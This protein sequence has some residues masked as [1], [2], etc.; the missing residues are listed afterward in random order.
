MFTCLSSGRPRV[1]PPVLRHGCRGDPRSPWCA[2]RTL[3]VPQLPCRERLARS[4]PYSGPHEAF[5][6]LSRLPARPSGPHPRP[7][8]SGDRGAGRLGRPVRLRSRADDLSLADLPQ[9]PPKPLRAAVAALR[10]RPGARS[11]RAVLGRRDGGRARG[12]RISRGK[13]GRKRGGGGRRAARRGLSPG[14]RPRGRSSAQVSHPG[15]RGGGRTA[16]GRSPRR[17][18]GD[19]P[20]GRQ[21][22]EERR[23]RAAAPRL[24]LRQSGGGAPSR[25]PG[26]AAGAGGEGGAG[27]RGLGVL[28]PS[29]RLP[30]RHRPRPVGQCARRRRAGGEH[31]Q[32]AAGQERLPVEPP[33]AQAQGRRGAD[34]RDARAAPRQEGDPRG[35]SERDL[36]RPQRQRQP[37]RPRRRRPRLLRQGR[38]RAVAPRGGDGRRDDRIAGQPLPHRPPGA[39]GRAAQPGVAAD[40]RPRLDLE[41]S[42]G[43][44]G[45]RAA[46]RP[47]AGDR[48]AADRPLLRPRRR[49]RGARALPRRRARRRRLSPLRHP[50]LARPAAGGDG[51]GPG[52]RRP[53]GEEG[54]Q[55][56]SPVGA[57]VG[58][59]ARRRRARLGGGARLRAQ[60]VRPRDPGA[61]PG[62]Q[63]LQAGGLRSGAGRGDRQPGDPAPGLADQRPHRQR[64]LAAAELRP[65][66]PRLG[67]GADGPRAEP[68]HPHRA[69]GDGEGGCRG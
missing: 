35:L 3:T 58:R 4:L 60:P 46:R 55:E 27:G 18:G 28:Y 11:R 42:D 66:L 68:E 31:D 67:H 62:R 10:Q 6:R 65:H 52:A 44:R 19:D 56:P 2:Q 14:R 17:A 1:A 13:R 51:G 39:V 12:C 25:H 53:R 64:Q 48:S 30:H 16:G 5:R 23:A 43:R 8:P 69:G 54:A 32:P 15:R 22:G 20:A 26:G 36:P 37:D 49:G 7:P 57:G 41:G 47:S 59:S 40:E 33:H 9:V 50:A 61:P 63:R 21:G 34:R 38:R 24:V 45:R 29:R